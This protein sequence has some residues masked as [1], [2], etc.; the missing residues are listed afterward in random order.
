[1]ST[2]LHPD[3]GMLTVF[4]YDGHEGGA[5]IAERG[6]TRAT[7]WL[8]ATREA[9]DSCECDHGC[10]SCIQSPKCGNSNN[11][12]DKPGALKLLATLLTL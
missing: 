12:L 7:D 2:E 4:V 11:P 9:I 8:R 10:P 5:G 3:T 1:M 6:F